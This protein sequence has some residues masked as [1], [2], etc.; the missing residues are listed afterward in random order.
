MV[1]RSP[2]KKPGAS[3]PA[4]LVPFYSG[5]RKARTD[6]DFVRVWLTHEA[7]LNAASGA[8]SD[9]AFFALKRRASRALA[10]REDKFNAWFW[11]MLD[12]A[13]QWERSP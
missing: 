13:R 10:M 6:V 4:A 1:K 12:E 2:G 11:G 9:A 5:L 7:A 3:A 8:A